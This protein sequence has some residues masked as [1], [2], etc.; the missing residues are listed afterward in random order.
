MAL[1]ERVTK[2]QPALGLDPAELA[3]INKG[4]APTGEA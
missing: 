4:G 2:P 1:R 3:V